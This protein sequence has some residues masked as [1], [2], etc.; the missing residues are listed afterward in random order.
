M[1]KTLATITFLILFV[2]CLYGQDERQEGVF[3]V[4]IGAGFALNSLSPPYHFV[5]RLAVSEIETAFW[6]IYR[7]N[8]ERVAFHRFMGK[9]QSPFNAIAIHP[10]N[11]RSIETQ[12]QE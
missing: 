7:P 2:P 3:S 1:I 8:E 9:T 6:F 4:S 10:V 12:P 5:D 11:R